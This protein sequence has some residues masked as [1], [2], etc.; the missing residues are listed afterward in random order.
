MTTA[1]YD[2]ELNKAMNALSSLISRKQRGD[3]QNYAT[4]YDYMQVYLDVSP[5]TSHSLVHLTALG[6]DFG[7]RRGAMHTRLIDAGAVA[8]VGT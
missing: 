8:E 5:S 4:A 2:D 7:H 1:E 6:K 3:G